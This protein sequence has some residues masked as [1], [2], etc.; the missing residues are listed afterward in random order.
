MV[1]GKS[2]PEHPSI[3]RRPPGMLSRPTGLVGK[4]RMPARG[5]LSSLLAQAKAVGHLQRQE[6]PVPVK[7]ELV[8]H[9][10]RVSSW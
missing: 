6:R 5:H 2:P 4:V 9:L 7:P 8:R 10:S 1:L 3:S